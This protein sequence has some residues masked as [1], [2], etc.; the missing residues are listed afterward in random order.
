MTKE[1]IL[2]RVREILSQAFELDPSDV[3][4]TAHLIDDLDL[5]SIDAIDLA[6]DLEKETG[7][8]LKEDELRAV[9]VVQDVVDLVHRRLNAE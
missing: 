2:E 9:R 8:S 7:L 1:E 6:V 5:D 3:V 4:P